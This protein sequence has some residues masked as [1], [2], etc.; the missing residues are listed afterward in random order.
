MTSCSDSLDEA[1]KLLAGP[2]W[3]AQRHLFFDLHEGRR[4]HEKDQ[5]IEN[6]VRQRDEV[7]WLLAF[8][9]W[10]ADTHDFSRGQGN[11]APGSLNPKSSAN[12]PSVS[13]NSP[14]NRSIRLTK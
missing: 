14:I 2:C 1:F 12:S 8:G 10:I 5:E 9:K 4:A 3:G 7:V 11:Y 13:F 6:H